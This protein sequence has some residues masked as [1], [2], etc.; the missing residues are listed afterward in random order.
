MCWRFASRA[1][2]PMADRFYLRLTC[3]M[4][5]ENFVCFEV[6]ENG[7]LR[8]DNERGRDSI[9]RKVVLGPEALD[10]LRA[11]IR[12]SD[13]LKEGTKQERGLS[14]ASSVTTL[15]VDLGSEHCRIAFPDDKSSNK[16][17]VEL[18]HT[19]RSMLLALIN[20]HFKTRPI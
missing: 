19:L 11:L 18:E 20:A 5:R 6:R 13:V 17:V 12:E 16:R 9:R 7:Q 8:Y 2:A 1:R 4:S 3:A 15:E 14:S 10:C